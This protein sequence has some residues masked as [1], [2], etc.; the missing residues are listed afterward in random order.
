M[1]ESKLQHTFFIMV[2]NSTSTLFRLGLLLLPPLPDVPVVNPGNVCCGVNTAPWRYTRQ[3]RALTSDREKNYV[4][5][6]RTDFGR[7]DL[8]P[9]EGEVL[10]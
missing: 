10:V 2:N 4:N 3:Y 5:M 1:H 6:P 8:V 7:H 9:Q